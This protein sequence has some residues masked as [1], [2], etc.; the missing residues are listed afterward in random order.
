MHLVGKY[1]QEQYY[2]GAVIVNR[3]PVVYQLRKVQMGGNFCHFSPLVMN[4]QEAARVL[5]A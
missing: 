1:G 5:C 4:M 2:P 3:D